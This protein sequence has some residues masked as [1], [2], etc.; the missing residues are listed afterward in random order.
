[1]AERV[2]VLI[3]RSADVSSERGIHIV[4][5]S[6]LWEAVLTSTHMHKSP[7]NK[8]IDKYMQKIQ[9]YDN[10]PEEP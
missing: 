5:E 10:V 7:V 2:K 8:K 4:G 1:M 3:P 9:R 6:Q